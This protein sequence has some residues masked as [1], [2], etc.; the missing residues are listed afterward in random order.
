MH[1]VY[2]SGWIDESMQK[3][4]SMLF[5]NFL[6]DINSGHQTI[7]NINVRDCLDIVKCETG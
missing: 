4:E 7:L 6:A 2:F 3:I 5:S 1:K